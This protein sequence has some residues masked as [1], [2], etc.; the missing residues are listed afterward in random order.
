MEAHKSYQHGSLPVDDNSGKYCSPVYLI[1]QRPELLRD[2]VLRDQIDKG[3]RFLMG[4]AN[5]DRVGDV[6]F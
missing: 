5:F 3:D 1:V 4:L 2:L 6:G